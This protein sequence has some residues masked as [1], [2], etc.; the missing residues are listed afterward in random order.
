MATEDKPSHWVRVRRLDTHITQSSFTDMFYQFGAVESFAVWDMDESCKK[1]FVRFPSADLAALAVSKMNDFIP[2]KQSQPIVVEHVT[3]SSVFAARNGPVEA[4]IQDQ[5]SSVVHL[6]LLATS[7]PQNVAH[8]IQFLGDPSG[9]ANEICSYVGKASSQRLKKLADACAAVLPTWH[10]RTQ[11]QRELSRGL[12]QLL[13]GSEADAIE[14]KGAGLLLSLLFRSNFLPGNA[15]EVASKLLNAVR[16]PADLEGV[17]LF[18]EEGAPAHSADDK[19][20]AAF[21]AQVSDMAAAHPSAA[22]RAASMTKLRQRLRR[23][24]I[25]SPPRLQSSATTATVA[26]RRT[27]ECRSRTVYFSHL[28]PCVTNSQLMEFLSES[29]AVMKVRRCVE[30]THSTHFGFVEMALVSQAQHL[31]RRDRTKVQGV[32]LLLE[33]A[34]SAVLDVDASDAVVGPDSVCTQ[35]CSFGQ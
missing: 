25:G 1:G 5:P 8:R 13:V 2:C 9:T 23:M 24:S 10:L 21:W 20:A 22:V 16:R 26:R 3:A 12:F 19:A 35:R 33:P 29:G 17:C 11:L 4:V 14:T 30:G 7:S 32:E 18:A 28:N 31:M 15:L 6:A 34:R 27:D